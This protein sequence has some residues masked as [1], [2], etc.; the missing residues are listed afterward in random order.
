MSESRGGPLLPVPH[1]SDTMSSREL[2]PAAYLPQAGNA[3]LDLQTSPGIGGMQFGL[4]WQCWAGADEAMSPSPGRSRVA[5]A[6][7]C[8]HGAGNRPIRGG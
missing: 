5:G 4:V 2:A 1:V 8:C 7:R 6:R 3:R